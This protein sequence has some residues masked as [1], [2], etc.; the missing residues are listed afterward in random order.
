VYREGRHGESEVT[1]HAVDMQSIET[2]V[3][4][5]STQ[6]H[7]NL[8]VTAS[9]ECKAIRCSH[10]E[11]DKWLCAAEEEGGGDRAT[12]DSAERFEMFWTVPSSS[13]SSSRDVPSSSSARVEVPP[14]AREEAATD[15]LKG[16]RP[17]WEAE[18]A[19]FLRRF[20]ESQKQ[21]ILSFVEE[22]LEKARRKL[23]TTAATDVEEG[24][25]SQQRE[26]DTAT[27]AITTATGPPAITDTQQRDLLP[28]HTDLPYTGPVIITEDQQKDLS[29]SELW[30]LWEKG[31]CGP[32]DLTKSEF[33]SEVIHYLYP[34]PFTLYPLPLIL[35]P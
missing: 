6:G 9:S 18:Q 1:Y 32:P 33:D 21:E 20:E 19:P 30:Q 23:R 13:S 28:S 27:A 22:V 24:E 4:G 31:A 26:E 29:L 8:H 3:L 12:A 25:A 16:L 5:V 11:L 2:H 14:S 7:H 17:V 34:L 10:A 35:N 15:C